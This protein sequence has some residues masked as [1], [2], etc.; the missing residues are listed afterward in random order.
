M[1]CTVRSGASLVLSVSDSHV[2]QVS[3]SFSSHLED[4]QLE[5]PEDAPIITMATNIHCIRPG[6]TPVEK[7]FTANR[8]LVC[9]YQ[10]AL[11]SSRPVNGTTGEKPDLCL[12]LHTDLETS[13]LRR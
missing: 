1:V 11:S 4:F 6:Q 2:V 5:N 3:A 9:F 10:S 13:L 7:V 12:T 8:V